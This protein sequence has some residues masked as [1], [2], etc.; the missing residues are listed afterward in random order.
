MRYFIFSL[1]LAVV[2]AVVLAQSH[3]QKYSISQAISEKA[4]THT[5]AFSGVAFLSGDVGAATFI[6]PGKVCD[7]FGF[8]YMRD[9]DSVRK[10]HNPIF[11]NRA[12]GTVLSILSEKQCEEMKQLAEQQAPKL[13]ELALMRLPLI[14]A[15]YEESES[16]ESKLKRDAVSKYVG[17]IFEL[18]GQLCLQ[19]AEM[20]GKIIRSLTPE[21]K[22]KFD[23]ITFG[24]FSTL[25]E[26]DLR[27]FRIDRP[28]DKLVNVAY[29]TYASE[30][31][32]W[33][34]GSIEAD[35]YFCPE[36]HGTYFGGFFMKDIPV[37]GKRDVDISTTI[38][39]DSGETLLNKIL[40]PDQRNEIVSLFV[41]QKG[42]MQKIVEL[43][44]EIS[45]E[46]RK[47]QSSDIIDTEKVL[48]L[49]REYGELDGDISYDYAVAFARINRSLTDLQRQE[50]QKLRN[51]DGYKPAAAYIYSSPY[52]NVVD[53]NTKRF[54]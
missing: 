45:T 25:L 54:F 13:R 20:F 12:A 37:M 43:R 29:T 23:T 8:Q 22:K 17:E 3:Q 36:R 28:K 24:D 4:Q 15:F 19:R 31:L 34:K 2:P 47:L 21:Q 48:K 38:T 50:I 11:V 35:T 10:G 26:K 30:F 46:L 32:S 6:P 53:W 40:L 16:K 9:I 51:L 1:I 27:D 49:A 39:G 52:E 18:D 33:Y 42:T 14:K 5:I 7:Y 41:K 44:R